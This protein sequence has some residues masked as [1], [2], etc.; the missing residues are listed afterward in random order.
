ME[1]LNTETKKKID[2]IVARHTGKMGP[3]KLMLHDV[4][5]E[6]GYIP[7]G[8]SVAEKVNERTVI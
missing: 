4:Q 2:E 3:V 1:K 7:F 6:C 5:H 8:G